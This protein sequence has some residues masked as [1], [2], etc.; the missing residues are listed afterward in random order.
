MKKLHHPNIVE[1]FQAVNTDSR[2]YLVMEHAIAGDM[3]NYLE[4]EFEDRMMTETEARLVFR[5]MLL[6]LEHCQQNHIVHG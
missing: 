1:L 5:Q 4:Y 3:E 2:L 6:A